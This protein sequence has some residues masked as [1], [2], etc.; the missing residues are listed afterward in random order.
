MYRISW[1]AEGAYL[2]LRHLTDSMSVSSMSE[3]LDR[4]EQFLD[5]NK[6]TYNN[7]FTGPKYEGDRVYY[8]RYDVGSRLEIKPTDYGGLGVFAKAPIHKGE[9]AI[10]YSGTYA[11]AQHVKK[12]DS[13][14]SKTSHSILPAFEDPACRS[15][16]AVDGRTYAYY[17]KER[18]NNAYSN[19]WAA[20]AMMNS[21]ISNPSL[22]N[23]ELIKAPMEDSPVKVSPCESLPIFKIQYDDHNAKDINTF[24]YALSICVA[25]EDIPVGKELLFKYHFEENYNPDY[26]SILL[27]P[28]P[29]LLNK[30]KRRMTLEQFSN[31]MRTPTGIDDVA[32]LHED[33]S[34]EVVYGAVC[35][36][37]R[38]DCD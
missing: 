35:T 26:L 19:V 2:P 4:F 20:G 9:V 16:M 14:Y 38:L 33:E 31:K 8:Q 27:P 1:E 17:L 30:P 23:V 36:F 18:P 21:S 29:T 6:S 32:I 37:P 5:S 22:T 34:Q 28:T 11:H 24:G 15:S 12:H 7:L 10:Y 3:Q 13:M 25:T